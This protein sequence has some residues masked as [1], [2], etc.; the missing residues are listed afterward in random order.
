MSLRLEKQAFPAMH[1]SAGSPYVVH[2]ADSALSG[3][4]C[5]LIPQHLAPGATR[6]QGSW[7][8]I[9]DTRNSPNMDTHLVSN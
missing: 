5:L 8:G 7:Y 6:F 9:F 3:Y 2:A 1:E 4:G